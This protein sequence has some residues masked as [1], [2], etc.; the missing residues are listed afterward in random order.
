MD[1]LVLLVGFSIVE[2]LCAIG[3]TIAIERD[4][5]IVIAQATKSDISSLNSS[6]RRID[7]FCGLVS[8][9]LTSVFTTSL[10][11]RDAIFVILA[12]SILSPIAEY[13][14]IY[15][16][17]IDIPEL[18][19]RTV[20]LSSDDLEP[21]DTTTSSNASIFNSYKSYGKSSIFLPSLALCFLY[22]T[23]LSFGAPM[24]AYLK[25]EGYSDGMIAAMR[26]MSV[27]V[28]LSATFAAPRII[29]KV[30]LERS[31]LWSLWSQTLCLVPVVLTFYYN[32]SRQPYLK[33][34]YL[35][36]F[37]SF[38]RLGL[39]GY[40]LTGKHFHNSTMV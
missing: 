33:L 20:A 22:L 11:T 40:D 10:S 7:L 32:M 26:S 14:L 12:T 1:W 38:S 18:A 39:W 8:P 9:M 24:V 16:V 29:K 37:L 36:G 25:I 34:L 15:K 6:M 35:F 17:Y 19:Q 5:V 13:Y 3:N 21:N 30:G 4:W 27:L 31:G 2:R 23:V 28:G